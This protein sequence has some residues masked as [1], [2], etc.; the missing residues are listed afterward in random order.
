MFWC[1][2]VR[3]YIVYASFCISDLSGCQHMSAHLW[4]S[5]ILLPYIW[6][7]NAVKIVSDTTQDVFLLPRW[8]R[9]NLIHFFLPI[10]LKRKSFF[11]VMD[12]KFGKC[13][14]IKQ[15]INVWTVPAFRS[16]KALTDQKLLQKHWNHAFEVEKFSPIFC[17]L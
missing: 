6:T 5:F 2:K 7:I 10:W 4:D 14:P 3:M 1:E 11:V 16:L 9:Y 13:Y 12:I 15:Q 8:C 17:E